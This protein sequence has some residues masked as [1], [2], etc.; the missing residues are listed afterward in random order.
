[1][2]L[3]LLALAACGGAK[4][5]RQVVENADEPV[6]DLRHGRR[7]VHVP[8]PELDFSNVLPDPAE[9]ARWPLPASLHPVLEPRFAIARALAEPGLTWS[10]LCRMGAQ[11]R[12]LP[13]TQDLVE[14]L[15]AWC[16]V[17]AHDAEGAVVELAHLQ[18]SAVLG[19]PDAIRL[20]FADVLADQ[21]GA[22]DAEKLLAKVNVSEVEVYDLLSATYFEIGKI[23]DAY[24]TAKIAVDAHAPAPAATSCRR[25]A[26][27]I[28]IAH[29]LGGTTATDDLDAY[30]KDIDHP[31]ETC[32]ALD[33][34]VR[35]AVRSDCAFYV[36]DLGLDARWADLVR[37]YAEWPESADHARWFWIAQQARSFYPFTGSAE[38]GAAALEGAYATSQCN[39]MMLSDISELALKFSA[40]QDPMLQQRIVRL[41]QVGVSTCVRELH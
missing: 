9:H 18:Q 12:R 7:T 25:I 15:R 35:C 23:E 6:G 33:H 36:R 21:A 19:L 37:L 4:P 30:T 1:M 29:E 3:A 41:R 40:P 27:R 24:E 13:G 2:K 39:A 34:E 26:K 8:R 32:F 28:V 10:D 22:A 31:D 38:L 20:D 14:Y 11:N 16:H 17:D 5:A